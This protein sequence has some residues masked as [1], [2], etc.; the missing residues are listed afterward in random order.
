M[1]WLGFLRI[2]GSPGMTGAGASVAWEWE[3]DPG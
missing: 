1:G 3:A 2:G